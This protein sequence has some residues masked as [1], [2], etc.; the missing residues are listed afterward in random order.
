MF[1]LGVVG[2]HAY[3]QANARLRLQ[4]ADHVHQIAGGGI[5]GRAE[6]THQALGRPAE[7]CAEFFETDRGVDAGAQR[8]RGRPRDCRRATAA[9]PQ[10]TGRGEI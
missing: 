4:Q 5:A 10:P 6:H 1:P 7:G 3:F 9:S 8:R 2:H